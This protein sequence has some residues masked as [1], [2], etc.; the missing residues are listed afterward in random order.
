[1][2]DDPA[3][4]LPILVQRSG[5]SEQEFKEYDAGTT[6]QSLSENQTNFKPGNTMTSLPYAAEQ[7]SNFL[8]E[9]GL[10]TKKPDLS[11]LLNSTFVDNAK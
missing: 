11:T 1:M 6:I 8:V 9:V 3:T 4:T 10:A 7:I 5:V 2:K